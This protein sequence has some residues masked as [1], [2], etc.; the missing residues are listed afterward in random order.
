MKELE[1]ERDGLKGQA[2][3]LAKEKDTLN[4]ALVEAQG[5]VLGKAEQLS[6]ANDSIK[7]LKLK[8]E[9]LEGTLSEVR[10]REETLTKDLEEERQLRRND[11]AN[12]EDYVKGENLWIS[13]LADVAGRITTQLATMGMPNVR[14]TPERN[15]SPNAKLTLF[16]E[17]VLGA[18]EQFRSNR[19]ASLADEARRLCRGAMT[20][21]LTKVAHWNPNLDFDAALESLPEDADLAT[22]EER[23]KPITSRIDGIQ[24]VEGLRRD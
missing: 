8:L 1:V 12:H 19:A 22:L 24:R 10:A 14:Y 21:V 4:G 13:R 11:A 5:A 17:G 16:F 20:K 7:D 23:I 3:K 18:L 9:G 15:V 6:K 2:L